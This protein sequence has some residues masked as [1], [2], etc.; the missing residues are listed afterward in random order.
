MQFSTK[1]LGQLL[2]RFA[3]AL[4]FSY[5]GLLAIKDP[6]ATANQFVNPMILNL[7]TGLVDIKFMMIPFGLAQ[8]VVALAI[9]FKFFLQYALMIA[10]L[11]L[12]SII[13]NLGIFS[14]NGI[15]QLALRDFVIF[16]GVV[17]LLSQVRRA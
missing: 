2:F 8:V 3:L 14:A 15:N 7:V 17:Y 6:V 1:E 10:A 13:I 4:I 16:S 12:L 5:F 11:M 9:L